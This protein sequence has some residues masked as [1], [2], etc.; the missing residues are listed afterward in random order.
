MREKSHHNRGSPLAM[1]G[2]G[3][4]SHQGLVASMDAV[5]RTDGYPGVVNVEIFQVCDVGHNQLY[6]RF[7][8]GG[9]MKRKPSLAAI[10]RPLRQIPAGQS[11]H[12]P[13][14]SPEPTGLHR[15]F[16]ERDDH[17]AQTQPAHG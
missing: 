16:R 11:T 14:L 15:G 12:P 5:K 1:G 17:A 4:G 9:F 7:F 3:Q 2:A 13:R 10:H 8:M 6:I